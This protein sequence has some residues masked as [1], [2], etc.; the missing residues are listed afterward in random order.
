MSATYAN[1]L[2]ALTPNAKWSMTNDADYN[3]ISWYST[4]IAKPTQAACDAEIASLNANA[5]NQ[6]CQQQASAL[7]Y[8]TDWATIPDVASTTNN[9][10]L[11]NQDEFIAYRNTVRKYAVN[12]VANPI[13]PTQPVAKWSA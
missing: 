11:T 1:A 10:Y 6:A 4:D 3:T 5:A 2:T 9:P 7:L 8:A 12:P 13:F